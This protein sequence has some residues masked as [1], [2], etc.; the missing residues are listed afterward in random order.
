MHRS[1]SLL[2]ASTPWASNLGP[3]RA[4]C[5]G[6]SCGPIASR[7]LIPGLQDFASGG[8]E[9]AAGILV[10]HRQLVP[11]IPDFLGGGPPHL[12]IGGIQHLAQQRPRNAAPDRDMNMRGEPLLRLDPSK[13]LRLIAQHPP[14]ILDE[15]V[16]QRGEVDRIP[17]RPHIVIGVRVDWDAVTLDLAVAVT[18]QGEEHGRPVSLAVRRG[19]DVADRAR[20]DLAGWT[21]T[22]GDAAWRHCQGGCL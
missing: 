7:G 1:A 11:G 16:E 4:T 10:P 18:R 9:V 12:V 3:N 21:G 19:V 20:G 17:R 15:P 13:V 22:G 14:Q 2:P 5:R 8:V 6:W